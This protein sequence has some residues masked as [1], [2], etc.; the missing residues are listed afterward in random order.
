MIDCA[1]DNKLM[2]PEEIHKKIWEI[3]KKEVTVGE[4]KEKE[5]KG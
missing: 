5:K 2:T 3:V 1:P 4:K